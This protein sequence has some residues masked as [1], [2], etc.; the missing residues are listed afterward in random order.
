MVQAELFAIEG[1]RLTAPRLPHPIPY[2]GSK[3]RLAASILA[4]VSGRK[5]RRLIE[6]FAGSAAITIAAASRDV[7]TEYVIGDSLAPLVQIWNQVI[8]E[9]TALAD[10]YEA[11]WNDQFGENL[12]HYE[13]VRASYNNDADPAKLLYLLARCVKNAPRFNQ[14]GAFNQSP[15]RRRKGMHP[16]KMR[17][18]IRGAHQLLKE[19]TSTFA[20]DFEDAL[21]DA[22]DCDLVYLDPPW[23]G[24]SVGRDKRY[25]QGLDKS[26]LEAVLRTLNERQVP[27]ILSYD[28][29]TG[30]KTYGEKLCPTLQLQRTDLVAGRSAQAT[31]N[32]KDAITVESLYLSPA[33]RDGNG[34]T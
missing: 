23:Q 33:V 7:A 32:G 18:E 28:G 27:F 12:D 25:H 34:V 10:R 30:D 31:L 26:R 2:Q 14:F 15:D 11:I 6:P 3:R 13:E 20:G 19:R 16:V 1:P 4:N 5:F 29:S 24:T 22:R 8:M 21:A 9:P 17:E